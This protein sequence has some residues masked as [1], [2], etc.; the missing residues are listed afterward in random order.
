MWTGSGHRH[1]REAR[2]SIFGRIGAAL[3][4]SGL[5]AL[6]L[7]AHAQ[8]APT[9]AIAFAPASI[10]SGA[11][12]QLS[13]AFSNPNDA[14]AVLTATLT[15]TLP[16][17]L[18]LVSGAVSGTCPA[19]AVHAG[20][21]AI[22]YGVETQI[23]SGGCSIAVTVKA[24][25]AV[26]VTYY[27][28]SI[29]A[30]A[31]QTTNGN[32]PAGASGTLA[33]HAIATVPK[34]TGLTQ[35][36]ALA[37]LQTAGLVVG[38]IQYGGAPAGTPFD[39]VFA[40]VPAAGSTVNSGSAVTLHVSTGRATNVNQPLTSTP[41]LVEPAQQSVAG[42]FERLCAELESPTLV[43]TASQ[44]NLLANCHAILD[45][46]GGGNNPAGLVNTLNAISGRQATAIAETGLFF[47]GTQF[48]TLATR[49]AQLRQGASG[50]SVTGFDSGSPAQGALAELWQ[51]LRSGA[52]PSA[53]AGVTGS[54][55]ASDPTGSVG[56]SS[57]D[58]NPSDQQSRWGFFIHGNLR[59]GTQD[60]TTLEQG[61]DYASTGFTVGVDYRAT[62]HLIFGA[63]LAHFN[64]TTNFNDGS[65]R[66]DSRSN[67]VS[68]YGT[69]YD[70]AWYLDV[71]GTY[72]AIPYDVTRTT[73]YAIDPAVIS[74]LPTNC[75]GATCT[76][77]TQGETGAR[78]ISFG[79]SLGYSWHLGGLELG[80]DVALDY[81][82][83]AVNG[84]SENDPSET[85]MGLAFGNQVGESLAL[86]AGGHAAYAISTPI[87]VVLPQL[88]A[89]YIHEF[90]DDQRALDVHFE[91]DPTAHLLSG[92]VSTFQVYSDAPDRS[93]M[94]WSAGITAQFPFGIA[95]FAQYSAIAGYSSIQ[96][97]EYSFGVRFQR[98][99]E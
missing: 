83:L 14:P 99:V 60:T 79:S 51:A 38:A 76:I 94:D 9:I 93:Y 36:G 53:G 84:F 70:E 27:T 77:D 24:T 91:N 5:L 50:L 56:G 7:A 97:R 17:G 55:P 4:A 63:A 69:W 43:L 3:A 61:F 92:P 25:S 20:G 37:A 57:G 67:S 74:P 6:P 82:H 40:Q 59:R 16:A 1:A 26:G 52:P 44:Q 75:S 29:P 15:D 98:L 13:I 19:G 42:G 78:Q 62:D 87:A 35:A 8:V 32:N 85:G 88:S 73:T 54:T 49:L 12:S 47:A 11:T 58:S 18:T 48:T 22:T 90:K 68:L 86:K 10:Q 65:G 30:G 34:V 41:G 72:A 45:T 89:R 96:L 39:T 31:L 23:P 66:L 80:P 28:D 81:V 95:A 46:Y 71:I 21:G 2:D 64:G 33:V